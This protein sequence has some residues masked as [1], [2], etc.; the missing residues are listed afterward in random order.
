MRMCN[1]IYNDDNK[2]VLNG[3][4]NGKVTLKKK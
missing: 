1:Q 3:M 2:C 4:N